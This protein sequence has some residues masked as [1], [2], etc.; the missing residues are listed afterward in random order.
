MRTRLPQSGPAQVRQSSRERESEPPG[1]AKETR[2]PI[3]EPGPLRERPGRNR[4][5]MAGLRP[6]AHGNP[7]GIAASSRR[8]SFP[9]TFAACH[10]SP[11]CFMTLSASA[12]VTAAEP[13]R[14]VAISVSRRNET[15]VNVDPL[16]STSKLYET[17]FIAIR[18]RAIKSNRGFQQAELQIMLLNARSRPV[19][20]LALDSFTTS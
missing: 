19:T 12:L 7:S 18:S 11:H 10:C 4:L 5:E 14:I 6:A 1:V 15:C 20:K 3:G 17:P 9:A 13:S 16:P 2:N 8:S